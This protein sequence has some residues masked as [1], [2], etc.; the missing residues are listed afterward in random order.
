MVWSTARAG[1]V[2]ADQ[3]TPGLTTYCPFMRM[4]RTV[5]GCEDDLR[6][7]VTLLPA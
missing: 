5:P 4:R 7:D 3:Q 1:L 2:L 6:R